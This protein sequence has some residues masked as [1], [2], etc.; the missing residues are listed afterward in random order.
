MFPHNSGCQRLGLI[1]YFFFVT[2][3]A[4]AQLV[5][6][7][8]DAAS[9]HP[10]PAARQRVTGIG[11]RTG[12][13]GTSD[14]DRIV[15]ESVPIAR[16]L[17]ESFGVDADQILG[18]LW[19]TTFSDAAMRYDIQATLPTGV[20]AQQV[21]DM[22]KNLLTERFHLTVH[23]EPR[24]VAGYALV[25]SRTGPKL[26]QSRGPVS[27]AERG[28]TDANGA[29][30]LNNVAADGFPR[31][32]P[33]ANFGASM[34]NSL[35]RMR[36]RDFKLAELASDLS[37]IV[38]T[39]VED[40]TSLHAEYDFT[41]EYPLPEHGMARIRALTGVPKDKHLAF[42]READESQLECVPILSSALEKQLGLRLEARK[43]TVDALVIDHLEK[44]PEEN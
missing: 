35:M 13:P 4:P 39:H 30:K 14:P 16:L 8:F 34:K 11:K 40:D 21:D 1:T 2:T 9:V 29:Y 37:Y 33:W 6:L 12:G 36:F 7:E 28:A 44:V 31:L 38:A 22:L 19:A 20:S 42:I 15:W 24:K 41:L 23:R 17:V 18:P 26:N 43:I 32:F 3:L 27:S 5:G 25:L 10:A